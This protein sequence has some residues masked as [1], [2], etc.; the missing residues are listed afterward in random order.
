MR[1][2]QGT[3]HTI[4]RSLLSDVHLID[5][6]NWKYSRDLRVII[7]QLKKSSYNSPNTHTPQNVALERTAHVCDGSSTNDEG[8]LAGEL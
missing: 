2:Y 5:S 1:W 6:E 4:W 7:E 3:L 8:A